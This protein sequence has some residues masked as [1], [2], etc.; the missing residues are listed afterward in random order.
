[1][2]L[3]VGQTLSFYEILGPLGAGAMGEVYRAR[4]TRLERDVALKVLPE[5]LA[6]DEERLLRFE[7]EAKA[8]ASLNHPNVAQVF[9]IDQVAGTCFMAMELVPGEDLATR[10]SRGSLALAEALDLCAQIAKGV[11]AAHEAG[12][13][14]RDLKPANVVV[15]PDGEVKVL[16]FGL[17]KPTGLDAEGESTT[18]NVLTTEKGRLLGT[19]T[20]MAPEQARGKSI[21][22]RVDVW[23][24]GC[25]LYEC[26]TG[27]RAYGGETISDVLVA[28]LEKEPDLA[29]L[30]S[31]TPP[32]LRVLL[33]RCLRKDPRRRLRDIGDAR[34]E[35]EELTSG[36]AVEAVSQQAGAHTSRVHAVVLALVLGVVAG[37]FGVRFLAGESETTE[38]SPYLSMSL[39]KGVVLDSPT[40]MASPIAISP[41]GRTVAFAAQGADQ[42]RRLYVRCV[43]ESVAHPLAGTEGAEYP[44]FSSDGMQIG[45]ASHGGGNLY[46]IHLTQG[47]VESIPVGRPGIRGASWGAD[48]T[49]VFAN[50]QGLARIPLAGG[51]ET[52]LTTPAA[53][54]RYHCWPQI[55]PDGDVLFTA[56]MREGHLEPRLLSLSTGEVTIVDVNGAAARYLQG[57]FLVYARSDE[58]LAVRFDLASRRVLGEAVVVQSGVHVSVHGTPFFAV[59]EDGRMR[60]HEPARPPSP[61][62]SLVWVDRQ[63]SA[64][65]LASGKGFEA[66]R[67]S[68]DGRKVVVAIHH[69]TGHDIWTVDTDNGMPAVVTSGGNDGTPVWYPSGDQIVFGSL[70]DTNL[71]SLRLTAASE[72]AL[73]LERESGQLPASWTP[74]GRLLFAE[75]T[76]DRRWDLLELDPGDGSVRALAV[77]EF[78]ETTGAVSPDGRW[79]AYVSD[80]TG[81]MEVYLLNYAE[82]GAKERLT[83]GGGVEPV[84]SPLGDELFFRNGLGLY[85]VAVSSD[86]DEPIG[87]PR[88][89]FE[90]DYVS[91]NHGRPNYDVAADASR[92]V[93][94]EQGLGLTVGHLDVSL[95]F[96][97]EI[98]RLLKD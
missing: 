41:D 92:F 40:G 89:L 56:A 64:E 49:L 33:E 67:L 66:P 10:L 36:G 79:L 80:E 76:E 85:A 98:G 21:D 28:V 77:S 1:M 38:A 57:G 27:K 86:A 29:A 47:T 88:M 19:P 65:P 17:A 68:P 81:S 63:G 58:I 51:T 23:A 73:L 59:S 42:V 94:I 24:F 95:D 9:G 61:G 20:Y 78:N 8:L 44:F 32:R 31:T 14:H 87:E 97:S 5:E 74:E 15:T 53:D 34:L 13:I 50:D 82:L 83:A 48:D 4:D 2:P 16:D 46:R 70:S 35:L 75:L 11:E 90:G 37:V 12:V 3:A 45:F 96:S 54:E 39:P 43:D 71:K 62:R 6:G 30:P 55:L 91:G 25:V 7:R 18:D 22:K 69:L 72:P 60:V 93:M 26:L 52:T 84:W